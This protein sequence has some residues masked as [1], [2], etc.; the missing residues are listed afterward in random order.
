ML[1]QFFAAFPLGMVTALI[2]LQYAHHHQAS[3]V[4]W[5]SIVSQV[6]CVAAIIWTL[7]GSTLRQ[8]VD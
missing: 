8:D 6:G 5:L 2:Q 1:S 4:S 7:R 3:G